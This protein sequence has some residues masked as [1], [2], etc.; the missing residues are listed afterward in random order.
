[1][2]LH[3]TFHRYVSSESIIHTA[4]RGQCDS[5]EIGTGNINAVGSHN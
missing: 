5:T 3:E 2:L 4:V 1:M